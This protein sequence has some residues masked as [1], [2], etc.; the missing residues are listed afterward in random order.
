MLT[1]S[2]VLGRRLDIDSQGY[3]VRALCLNAAL[4]LV[5]PPATCGGGSSDGSGRAPLGTYTL[6]VTATFTADSTTLD[7]N[8]DLTLTAN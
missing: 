1:T 3:C 4:F 6:G 7:R 8:L 2:F 5:L